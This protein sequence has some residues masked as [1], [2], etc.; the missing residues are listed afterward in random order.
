MKTP[1]FKPKITEQEKTK[2][3]DMKYW[4][5]VA[6]CEFE[7]RPHFSAAKAFKRL[8]ETNSVRR[9]RHAQTWYK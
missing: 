6:M 7:L 3:V 9:T 4:H 1:D 2:T 5:T 8:P